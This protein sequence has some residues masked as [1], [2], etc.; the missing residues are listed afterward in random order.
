VIS[1]SVVRVRAMGELHSGNMNQN[2]CIAQQR[3]KCSPGNRQPPCCRHASHLY[4]N[5]SD[6]RLTRGGKPDLHMSGVTP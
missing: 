5:S 6:L 2:G 4:G 3:L 1:I